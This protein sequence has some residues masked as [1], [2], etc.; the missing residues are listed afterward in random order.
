MNPSG[1]CVILKVVMM[2]DI[3][4]S[5]SSTILLDG[6]NDGEEQNRS[7]KRDKVVKLVAIEKSAPNVFESDE[8]PKPRIAVRYL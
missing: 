7:Y 1:L 6:V 8:R 5:P 2:D 3:T 4:A